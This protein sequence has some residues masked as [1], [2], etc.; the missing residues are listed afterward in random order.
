MR[1]LLTKLL[2]RRAGNEAGFTLVE[3]LVVIVIIVALAAAIIPAVASFANR[4]QTGAKAAELVDVQ[5]AMDTMMADKQIALVTP[6]SSVGAES[7]INVWTAQPNV[8][9]VVIGVETSL[10]NYLRLPV[11]NATIYFYCWNTAGL[12]TRQDTVATLC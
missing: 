4:G 7:S 11:S 6:Q 10:V 12:I 9:S 5:S 2:A 8:A 3:L 1:N